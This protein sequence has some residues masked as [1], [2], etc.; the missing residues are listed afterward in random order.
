[1]FIKILQKVDP[2]NTKYKKFS[3]YLKRHIELD[4]DEHGNMALEIASKLIGD[5]KRK[6]TEASKVAKI[7][8]RYRTL[9][10]DGINR[11]IEKEENLNNTVI[12]SKA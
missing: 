6:L 3:Y 5:D 8:L 1:M 9:L 12:L 2:H 7:A 4:G 11:I 10:W